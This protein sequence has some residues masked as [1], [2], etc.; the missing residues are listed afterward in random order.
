MIRL[1]SCPVCQSSNITQ[2]G[3][4]GV[5]PGLITHEIMPGVKVNAAIVTR[6]NVCQS[7]NIIFQNPR[8]PQALEKYYSLGVYRKLHHWT[9]KKADEGELKRAQTDTEIIKKYVNKLDSH[10]DIGCSRGYLLDAIGAK[11][12]VGVEPN[13]NYVKTKGVKVYQKLN[14]VPK[15]PFDLV[16]A[17]HV[18]EHVLTPHKY[19]QK[20][21]EF[22]N[23]TGYLVIEVPFEERKGGSPDL[24]HLFYFEPHVLRKLCAQAGLHVIH[25]ESTPHLMLICQ[26]DR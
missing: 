21:A 24:A 4:L 3:W 9:P 22:I 14:Q 15:K 12:K 19:L 18:L 5:S 13:A 2:Y 25:E 17:I 1:E 20:M 7:C 8:L 10:L 23:P 6:Y 11:L 26:L 16:T